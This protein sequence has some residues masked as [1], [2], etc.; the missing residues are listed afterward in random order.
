LAE[1]QP[2]KLH[3]ASSNLVSRSTPPRSNADHGQKPAALSFDSRSSM[4]SAV[5][6]RPGQ[7]TAFRYAGGSHADV[8]VARD[9]SSEIEWSAVR[10]G[11]TP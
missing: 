9:A 7:L 6:H 8:D 3:V 11:T 5:R 10:P 4:S 1:R 2:S